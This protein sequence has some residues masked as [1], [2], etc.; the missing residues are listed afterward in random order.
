MYCDQVCSPVTKLQKMDNVLA[1]HAGGEDLG[2]FAL[3]AGDAGS[4]PAAG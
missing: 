1:K 3:G 2:Y 4:S